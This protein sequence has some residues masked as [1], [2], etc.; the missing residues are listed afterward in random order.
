MSYDLEGG[1]RGNWGIEWMDAN[2][3]HELSLLSAN[4]IC[5]SCEHSDG[6]GN[7]NNS[8]L[9]C[10]LKGQAAWWLWARLAGWQEV[11]GSGPNTTHKPFGPVV[12]VAGKRIQINFERETLT[13]EQG[14]LRVLSMTGA[15]VLNTPLK[16]GLNEFE[17]QQAPGIYILAL[18]SAEETYYQKVL[19]Q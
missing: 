9:H 11:V 7:D 3:S 14:T 8:R 18:Q 16:D 13:G 6:E 5:R 15:E 10:V 2:P 1:G 17:I 19:I 4:D 12:I